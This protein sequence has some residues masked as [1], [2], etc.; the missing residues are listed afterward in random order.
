MSKCEYLLNSWSSWRLLDQSPGL[1]LGPKWSA[2]AATSS[3]AGDIG[4]VWLQFSG[5]MVR[6]KCFRKRSLHRCCLLYTSPGW[7]NVVPRNPLRPPAWSARTMTTDS[8]SAG[9]I[10]QW[11]LFR[12]HGYFWINTWNVTTT[13]ILMTQLPDDGHWPAQSAHL[14]RTLSA[15]HTQIG[16]SIADQMSTFDAVL[17]ELTS[18]G[19]L[20]TSHLLALRTESIFGAHHIGWIKISNI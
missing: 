12:N 19:W 3:S 1:Q 4:V 20:T 2:N 15:K 9:A 13:T 14:Q 10:K 6:S 11:I 18:N 16:W 7:Q 5:T 8:K 17:N